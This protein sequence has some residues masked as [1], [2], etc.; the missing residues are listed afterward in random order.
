MTATAIPGTE[1]PVETATP[2]IMPVIAQPATNPT[3]SS[4]PDPLH[5][6]VP[7]KVRAGEKVKYLHAVTYANS[8]KWDANNHTG[9]YVVN[10]FCGQTLVPV[11]CTL[12]FMFG[13]GCFCHLCIFPIPVPICWTG[14]DGAQWR[15]D[16][17]GAMMIVDEE[18][19]TIA[20]FAAKCSRSG[21]IHDEKYY[22]RCYEKRVGP[23]CKKILFLN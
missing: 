8:I 23:P 2:T 16:S 9:C 14:P 7:E 21:G 5:L 11:G 13:K 3:R 20:S 10:C 6:Q 12:N 1:L 18:K 22:I 17:G 4:P 19:G 15:D